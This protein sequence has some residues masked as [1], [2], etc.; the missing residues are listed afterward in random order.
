MPAG[1][2]RRCLVGPR[3]RTRLR[4]GAAAAS[5]A[6]AAAAGAGG[7]WPVSCCL[8]PKWSRR[9]SRSS[10]GRGAGVDASSRRAGEVVIGKRREKKTKPKNP[11]SERASLASSLRL[12]P[13]TKARRS[14]EL[15]F[16]SLLFS[17]P[18]PSQLSSPLLSSREGERT[19]GG[20][21]TVSVTEP[22]KEGEKEREAQRMEASNVTCRFAVFDRRPPLRGNLPERALPPS[23]SARA[24]W[25]RSRI[26]PR[27]DGRKS[28]K[29][30]QQARRGTVTRY[31]KKPL[32]SLTLEL[33][34]FL[35]LF[36]SQPPSRPSPSHFRQR[37]F[38]SLFF[39]DGPQKDRDRAHHRREE[40]AGEEKEKKSEEESKS[41]FLLFDLDENARPRLATK[42]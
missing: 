31:R 26:E 4:A 6:A 25:D 36:L 14:F 32:R 22:G 37:L 29:A 28:T 15:V 34:F 11:R 12:S 5:A 33:S 23:L 27:F 7:S 40:P 42:N 20:G 13:R 39:Q 19:T 3:R 2:R 17:L 24:F 18:V 9:S 10:R 30:P 8:P 16:S 21:A 38:P 41:L 35:Y 1:A